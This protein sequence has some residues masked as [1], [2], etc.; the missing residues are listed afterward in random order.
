MEQEFEA[1]VGDEVAAESHR[2]HGSRRVG[3]ILEVLGTPGHEYYR[4]E[5]QDGR[6]TVFHP[7]ADVVL[8]P[9]TP[10][11]RRKRVAPPPAPAPPRARPPVERQRPAIRAAAGDRLI[12]HGHHLGEPDRDAEILE[13]LGDDGG[14]PYRVRW[15][16]SGR[17]ALLFPGTDAVVEHIPHRPKRRPTPRA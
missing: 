3:T 9:K 15:S 8:V 2:L 16:E 10:R 14:P 11:R 17:E 5:W 4:V 1:R 6:E 13:V 7:G 12:I